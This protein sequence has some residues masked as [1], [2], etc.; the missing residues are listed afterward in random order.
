[1]K[2]IRDGVV[3]CAGVVGEDNIGPK[4]AG[5][6]CW[7][8]KQ[9]GVNP[10]EYIRGQFDGG[11]VEDHGQGLLDQQSLNQLRGSGAEKV[12]RIR[13]MSKIVIQNFMIIVRSGICKVTSRPSRKGQV[14]HQRNTSPIG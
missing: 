10:V 14:D 3:G 11:N 6:G 4:S 12:T 13:Q 8:Q 1:M 2:T 9:A 5:R 7:W